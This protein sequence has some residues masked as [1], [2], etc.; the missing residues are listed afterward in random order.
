[1]NRVPEPEIELAGEPRRHSPPAAAV[2]LHALVACGRPEPSDSD[3]TY[4]A[5]RLTRKPPQPLDLDP[6]DL[7]LVNPRQPSQPPPAQVF[8]HKTPEFSGTHKNTL[9]P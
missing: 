6:T 3:P 9:P 5:A 7:D 4:P 2:G 1:L 8:L